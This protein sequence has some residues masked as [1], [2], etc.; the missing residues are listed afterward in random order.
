MKT[1]IDLHD[2]LVYEPRSLYII[3]PIHEHTIRVIIHIKKELTKLADLLGIDS[4]DPLIHQ[5]IE[6]AKK[7]LMKYT[8]GVIN[9]DMLNEEFT[10]YIGLGEGFTPAYDDYLSGLL[11]GVNYYA[12]LHGEGWIILDLE[13]ARG[14]S[15]IVSLKMIEYSMKLEVNEALDNLLITVFHGRGDLLGK[16]ID[17]LTL[18]WSSGYYMS[19]GLLDSVE[20]ISRSTMLRGGRRLIHHP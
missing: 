11:A 17:M 9:E 1:I 16:I 20:I 13:K 8:L 4:Y 19:L 6:N 5:A 18:G 3:K 2:V 15:N 14:R 7:T 12:R 10:K